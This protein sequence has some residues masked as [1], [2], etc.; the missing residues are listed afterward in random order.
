MADFRIGDFGWGKKE[1]N[2]NLPLE[3]YKSIVRYMP[4]L[5]VDGIIMNDKAQFLLVKRNNEP[6]KNEWWIPGGRVYK[7]E[8]LEKA[9]KRKMREE[10]GVD[11]EIMISLGYYE[12]Q[13]PKSAQGI[14]V[15]TLSI[16]FSAVALSKDIVLDSQSSEYKWSKE[17]P[18]KLRKIKPF[19]VYFK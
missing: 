15:H 16:V 3:F 19:N 2:M 13:Y 4:I 7:G 9:F 10:I 17:L 1:N 6:L 5:C 8:T 11:V 18:E 14:P 12:E